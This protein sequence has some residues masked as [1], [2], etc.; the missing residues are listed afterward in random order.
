MYAKIKN[1]VHGVTLHKI[2]SKIDNGEIW[3]QKKLKLTSQIPPQMSIK[4]Q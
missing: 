3:F 4:N 2:D 1:L